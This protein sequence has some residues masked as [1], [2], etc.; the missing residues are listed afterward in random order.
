MKGLGLY[1]AVTLLPLRSLR[2]A[3][4]PYSSNG[5]ASAVPWNGVGPIT[6]LLRSTSYPKKISRRSVPTWLEGGW[7]GFDTAFR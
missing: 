1:V 5:G 4:P 3:W 6:T 2:G 7:P